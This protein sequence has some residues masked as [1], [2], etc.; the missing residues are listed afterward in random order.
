MFQIRLVPPI[1]VGRNRTSI[2][3]RLIENLPRL[4]SESGSYAPTLQRE[5]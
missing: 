3:V 2:N 4:I 5:A 1:T